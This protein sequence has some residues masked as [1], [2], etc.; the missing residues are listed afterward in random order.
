MIKVMK[1]AKITWVGLL[2]IKN[3]KVLMVREFGQDFYSLPGGGLEKGETKEQS[4]L[5]EIKE[6]LNVD[7]AD[8][9]IYR[10]YNLPGRLEKTMME[11]I[12]YT[13]K[14][15]GKI[16]CTKHIQEIKWIDSRFALKDL[17]VGNVTSMKLFPELKKKNLID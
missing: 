7:V 14:V 4:L 5:R 10:K 17:K 9:R 8:H 1:K 13:G 16:Q 3:R 12:I 15:K 6:E 11:F 2:I